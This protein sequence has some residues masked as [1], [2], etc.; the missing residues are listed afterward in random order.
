M[1]R[2]PPS[3]RAPSLVLRHWQETLLT[4]FR[5]IKE[6]FALSQRWDMFSATGGTRYRMWIEARRAP[7][8]EWTLLYRAQDEEH[9]FLSGPLAFRRVRNVYN[10]SRVYGAK[11]AYPAFASWLARE[12]FVREP[13]FDEMRVGM[14]RGL[15]LARG[16]GF[17]PSGEFDYVLVRRRDEVLP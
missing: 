12:I 16:A 13:A 17:A 11:N 1:D 10:P 7:D 5:P 2:L 6:L 3:L 15:I 4:P 9:A 14:E 8:D